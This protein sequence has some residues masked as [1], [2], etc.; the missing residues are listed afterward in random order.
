M[1]KFI[2]KKNLITLYQF[3]IFFNSDFLSS[4]QCFLQNDQKL[5]KEVGIT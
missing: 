5:Q 3:L 4:T 2:I 1:E